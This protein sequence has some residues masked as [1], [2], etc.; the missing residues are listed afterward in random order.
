MRFFKLRFRLAPIALSLSLLLVQAHDGH[1][2]SL[3]KLVLG[4]A[5]A[6]LAVKAVHSVTSSSPVSHADS[7]GIPHQAG[8]EN[9]AA[10]LPGGR[11]PTFVNPRLALGLQLICYE[12]YALGYSP[13]TRT[14]LWSAEYLT[15]SRIEAA[16]KLPRTNTFH[17]ET[18]I[19]PQSRATL[20][21]FSGSGYDRGHLSP[22]K[23]FSNP[24]S[25]NE[26][27]S[28]ANMVAQNPYNNQHTW[29]S[30]ESGTRNFASRNGS[31]YVIT[32]PLFIGAKIL[33]LKDRVA[34]PT[35][36][37]KVL[38]DP[39]HQAGGVFLVDNSDTD[40]IEWKSIAEF[41]S[42]SGYQLGLGSPALMAMPAPR[43]HF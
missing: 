33:F 3:G 20:K 14:A 5:A 13:T 19:A 42:L 16:K 31:V 11:A 10:Q 30:I 26:S 36:L 6:A 32:G 18:A 1:A 39:V 15:A 43:Q 21:D 7:V 9:C 29:E 40:V 2:R 4:T 25:Q 8:Q 41:E 28:L 12:E 34:I 35:K 22:N 27:F 38:F 24:R 23:D 17:E 37:F